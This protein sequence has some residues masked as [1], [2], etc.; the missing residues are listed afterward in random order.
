M[1]IHPKPD[2]PRS[3]PP[4]SSL[5]AL[6]RTCAVRGLVVLAV[7]LSLLILYGLFTSCQSDVWFGSGAAGGDAR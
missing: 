5:D 7:P 4:D 2:P 1:S 6:E 3:E